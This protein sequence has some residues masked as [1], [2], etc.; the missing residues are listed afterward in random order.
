MKAKERIR[1]LLMVLL[2]CAISSTGFVLFLQPAGINAGGLTGVSMLVAYATD[3]PWLSVGT[4]NILFNIPLFLISYRAIGK[5]FFFGSLL[6]MGLS[7]VLLDVLGGFLPT[8]TVEPLV[9]VAFGATLLGVGVG[10][11]FLAGASTGGVDILARMLKLKMR[12]FPLG[13]I[14]LMF[15]MGTAVAT[16]I[17]YKDFNNTLYSMLALFLVSTVLDKV[18][19]SGDYAQLAIIAT[20]KTEEV[21]NAISKRLNRGVTFLMSQGYYLRK[22]KYM[23]LSVVKRQQVA[24]LKELVYDIDADA[25]L[26]LQDAK[27]VLG[28]GFKRYNKNDL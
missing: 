18:L 28:D 6:G 13:K 24:Q 23:I 7:S 15:D 16:G 8:P 20:D 2:G 9:A 1:N 5:E 12:N 22:N 26:I 27:Q 21:A 4:I 17:V 25:F 11:V 10:L 14:I 3:I 19:Y